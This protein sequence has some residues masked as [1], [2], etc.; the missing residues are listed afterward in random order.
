VRR[1]R[2]V[3]NTT[4]RD[5]SEIRRRMPFNPLYMHSEDMAAHE[6]QNNMEVDIVSAHGAIRARIEADDSMRRGVISICHGWGKLPGEETY[7]QDGASVNDLIPDTAPYIERINSMPWFT[8]VPVNVKAV[9][10]SK[11]LLLTS[12]IR[13]PC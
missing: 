3:V 10:A 8:A 6:F 7:D 9:A 2:E 1:V 13:N 4:Y 5:L 12:M 11:S